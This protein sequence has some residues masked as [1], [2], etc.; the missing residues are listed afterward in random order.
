MTGLA[1]RWSFVLAFSVLLLTGCGPFYEGMAEARTAYAHAGEGNIVIAV[2]DDPS[3]PSYL[4]GVRLAADRLNASGGLLERPVELLVSPGSDDFDAMLPTVQRIVRNPRVIAVLGHKRSSVAVPASVIYEQARVL[5]MPPFANSEQLTLHGFEFVLRMLPD[6]KTMAVQSA[7]LASLFG[8]RRIAVLHSRDDYSRD[9]AFLFEDAVRR[10][11]IEIVFSGSFFGAETNYRGLIGQLKGLDFDAV[12]LSTDTK[13]GAR[14]L[15]QLRELGLRQPVL[16]SDS[17]NYGPLAQLAGKAGDQTMVPSVYTPG[18]NT[19]NTKTRR[20]EKAY[21]EV[22]G[23][24]PTQGAAQGYDG[25][26]ILATIVRQAGGTAPRVLATTAHYSAPM[27]GVTGIYAFDPSGNIFGK[28]YRFQVLRFGR[29]WSLP[30]ITVPFL[31]SRFQDTTEQDDE[32]AQPDGGVAGAT[33]SA[34]APVTAVGPQSVDVDAQAVADVE[35]VEDVE[36]DKPMDLA[37]LTS[38]ELT[39]IER[40]QLWLVL[41][42]KILRFKRLGLVA[43]NSDSSGAAAIGLARTVAEHR[44]FEVEICLL[45]DR[46]SGQA[47]AKVEEDDDAHA[48]FRRAALACYSR[49]ARTVDTMF[50]V[51]DSGLSPDYLNRLNRGLRHFGVPSFALSDAV[52]GD[53]GLTLAITGS[54]VD[55]DDPGVALRFNGVLKSMKVHELNR[56]FAN[57]PSVSVDLQALKEL[58]FHPDPRKLAV[59]SN[60]LESS[61]PGRDPN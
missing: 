13:P 47:D 51:L 10:F 36:K 50:V 40:R 52:E 60:V 43:S 8:Y 28:S 12:Y 26:E 14:I 30:G 24:E 34:G 37:A 33:S 54:D 35:D 61:H 48:A 41:A 2:I 44:G 31:L 9:V 18:G 17:L 6:N 58:G 49:L 59:V 56:K 29:W 3:D 39:I 23:R 27:A 42:H 5:F 11:G 45:P 7:S 1:P 19:G 22:Y 53:Y 21:A 4:D 46:N 38:G 25:V 16:G 32:A 20:F 15:T 57:L 55:L